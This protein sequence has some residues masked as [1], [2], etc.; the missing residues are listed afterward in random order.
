[1]SGNCP[2][3]GLEDITQPI[4]I[5][6]LM[7][8]SQDTSSGFMSA[9]MN[10]GE[11]LSQVFEEN[12]TTGGKLSDLA[13]ELADLENRVG[14]LE[15]NQ[16]IKDLVEAV[17]HVGS[18][19]MTTSLEWN[20][21]EALRKFFGKRTNWVLYPYVPYGVVSEN[22]PLGG[23][24]PLLKG[25][26]RSAANLRIWERLPD[27]AGNYRVNITPDKTAINEGDIVTF[28]ITMIGVEPGTLVNYQF[29]AI[30][31]ADLDPN[32][33]TKLEGSFINSG[34]GVNTLTLKTVP[35]R[36]NDGD[37]IVSLNIPSYQ[38]VGTF[39]LVD[40]SKAL[41]G[42]INVL[43]GTSQLIT[44]APN[45]QADV[46]ITGGGGSGGISK[47]A[48]AEVVKEVNFLS[49]EVRGGNVETIAI[50]AGEEVELWLWGGGGDGSV[51]WKATYTLP[52]E[53]Y[54]NGKPSKVTIGSAVFVA[55][56]GLGYLE[57]STKVQG[58]YRYIETHLPGGANSIVSGDYGGLEVT[59]L[60]NSNG[61]VGSDSRFFT[62]TIWQG[63]KLPA[64]QFGTLGKLD[65]IG[66]AHG[67]GGTGNERIYV[68]GMVH[69][70]AGGGSGGFIKLRV[71]NPTNSLINI[72]AEAG[73]GGFRN[74]MDADAPAIP[75]GMIAV[76]FVWLRL[77]A[78]SG[79]VQ[80][81]RGSTNTIVKVDP[82][83][84]K[85]IVI[86]AGKSAEIWIAG[87]GGSG[88]DGGTLTK[89]NPSEITIGS[90]KYI[91]NGGGN[92]AYFPGSG[93]GGPEPGPVSGVNVIP[94][95]GLPSGVTV[96]VLLNQPGVPTQIVKNIYNVW[97]E[98]TSEKS[99]IYGYGPFAGAANTQVMNIAGGVN[100][101]PAA[102]SLMKLLVKNN[103]TTPLTIPA[104]VG[105]LSIS[106]ISV[107]E[108]PGVFVDKYEMMY[109][110]HGSPG[111]VL[112]F[113][114]GG[115]VAPISDANYIKNTIKG[116]VTENVVLPAGDEIELWL[117]GGGGSSGCPRFNSEWTPKNGDGG[118]SKLVFE[119]NS[120]IAGGGKGHDE[121]LQKAFGNGWYAM[122]VNRPGG[123]NSILTP[124]ALSGV[125]ISVIEN[126]AGVIGTKATTAFS[127]I[128]GALGHPD[129]EGDC[130][131]NGGTGE[132][133]P[134][135]AGNTAA[136]VTLGGGGSGGFLRLRIKN[137]RTQ[138]I[139][140][141]VTTGAGGSRSNKDY[142]VMTGNNGSEGLAQIL[143]FKSV[144]IIQP[145][146]NTKS[147]FTLPKGKSAEIWLV[148]AG[149]AVTAPFIGS[150]LGQGDASSVTI[151]SAKYIAGGGDQKDS[152]TTGGVTTIPTSGL[153]AGV[154]VTV[155]ENKAGAQPI[156]TPL[157][158]GYVGVSQEIFNIKGY[159]PF[160]ATPDAVRWRDYTVINYTMVGAGGA[161]LAIKVTNNSAN[162]LV[163]P[164]E[165]GRRQV[166]DSL[167]AEGTVDHTPQAFGGKPTVLV[168]IDGGGTS[169]SVNNIMVTD[170]TKP[171]TVTIPANYEMEFILYGS[172]GGGGAHSTNPSY[173]EQNG[174]KGGD[175]RLSVGAVDIIAH[176][177]YGGSNSLYNGMDGR[178]PGVGGE[179]TTPD[180]GF[181]AG[182]SVSYVESKVGADAVTDAWVNE[183]R[184]KQQLG[185]AGYTENGF[186]NVGGGGNSNVG[187]GSLYFT[188]AGGGAG[189]YVKVRVKNENA[190]PVEVVLNIG[191]GGIAG[192]SL[193]QHGNPGLDGGAVYS[194]V[195]VMQESVGYNGEWSYVAFQSPLIS[196]SSSPYIEDIY[197]ATDEAG[198]NPIVGSNPYG[199][200]AYLIIKT[201]DVD[202]SVIL[203]LGSS[204]LTQE[205]M[206]GGELG[207][208]ITI[209]ITKIGTTNKGIGSY[210]I[211][212]L[213]D[214]EMSFR[215]SEHVTY[216]VGTERKANTDYTNNTDYTI[217]VSCC[218]RDGATSHSKHVV[219]KVDGKDA[220]N[221][222][223]F[224]VG[225][226]G[227]SFTVPP[228][229]KYNIDAGTNA[230]ISWIEMRYKGLK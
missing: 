79:A 152:V 179:I 48:E 96:E 66:N 36:R 198:N 158:G 22:V 219:V 180:S 28:T 65:I 223:D 40:S 55:G 49:Q 95:A 197:W 114:E 42:V 94:T 120:Y 200:H 104:K 116:G 154:E 227:I 143:E 203:S 70:L 62:S 108:N 166:S 188:G 58:G 129:K 228:G 134:V 51:A 139:T 41:D 185:A 207:K 169:S 13:T 222:P 199:G 64:L 74:F 67:S 85:D 204:G 167:P 110:A 17:F 136:T 73:E 21:G 224:N 202:D 209:P 18:K 25:T 45:Q 82:T 43:P 192:T 176:G 112:A 76:D 20:P 220:V 6:D 99:Y 133:F 131:G 194:Q 2:V 47:G 216:A 27:N 226:H 212:T 115:E 8:I 135:G 138:S 5:G 75:E 174:S 59:V 157:A 77:G 14:V 171:T 19:H 187:G 35:N 160:G 84:T 137:N 148:G 156:V 30:D 4:S 29:L 90:A 81:I 206:G 107:S 195:V 142:F 165:L 175:T 80:V 7:I 32:S 123:V 189:G 183:L 190:L 225:D 34:S 170:T 103:N 221:I 97:T 128:Y 150:P 105:A 161:L 201:I 3:S 15:T 127:K 44:L 208:E 33:E 213:D 111:T 164:Y 26:G 52:S 151:G 101:A 229:K 10:V 141:P 230:I 24:V 9:Q 91:A 218:I 37:R 93:S 98:Y 102:G 122:D 72:T 211:Q 69:K 155:I 61:G 130:I 217:T 149:A 193:D 140:L 1:M 132:T 54:G 173:P 162:D 68:Q 87:G 71:K 57:S 153:P 23:I 117:W 16:A 12:S 39:V 184:W 106:W 178:N 11:F 113:V 147:S 168:F 109:E 86:P 63:M 38:A 89:G 60:E 78:Q 50:A 196:G 172:G 92:S 126:K 144:D 159:G 205:E 100:R 215:N 56:G 163:I 46:W 121:S 53:Y 125:V 83:E 124:N 145:A 181:P 146:L 119:G 210:L 118:D 214:D 31:A 182:V 191:N 177:G 88:G 186:T